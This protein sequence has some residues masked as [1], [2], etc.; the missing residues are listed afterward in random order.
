LPRPWTSLTAP[1]SDCSTSG[2]AVLS[3]RGVFTGSFASNGT[4]QMPGGD[5]TPAPPL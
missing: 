3:P 2:F 4:R 1:R 5:A